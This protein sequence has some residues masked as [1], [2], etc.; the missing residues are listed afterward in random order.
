[1]RSSVFAV[2]PV[3]GKA[4]DDLYKGVVNRVRGSGPISVLTFG[5]I[6]NGDFVSMTRGERLLVFSDLELLVLT[7]RRASEEERRRVEALEREIEQRPALAL[8]WPRSHVDVRISTIREF[9]ARDERSFFSHHL[10]ANGAVVWGRDVIARNPLEPVG[11]ADLRR[12]PCSLL[13]DALVFGQGDGW[14]GRKAN[15][16]EEVQFVQAVGTSGCKLALM[17]AA[18]LTGTAPRNLDEATCILFER[19]MGNQCLFQTC[20]GAREASG[21]SVSDAAKACLGMVKLF[22][23]QI[24]ARRASLSGVGE[25]ATRSGTH[26]G[27]VVREQVVAGGIS[28]LKQAADHGAAVLADARWRSLRIEVLTLAAVELRK[29]K[30]FFERFVSQLEG[31]AM[32][33]E[34]ERS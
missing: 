28:L 15:L 26:S 24:L 11:P 7:A 20:R 23:E 1:M 4:F 19:G 27:S 17:V 18:G 6:V 32:S 25:T 21:V 8:C 10:A 22:S 5:S 31:K 13:L 16:A 2:P 3:V 34:N 30:T 12:K 9:L 33:S 29:G 14:T